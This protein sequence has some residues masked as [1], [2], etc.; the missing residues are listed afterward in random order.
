MRYTNATEHHIV[1][2]TDHREY[3]YV[4]ILP[5]ESDLG[6]HSPSNHNGE[7]DKSYADHMLLNTIP[8]II[9]VIWDDEYS[10]TC[11]VNESLEYLVDVNNYSYLGEKKKWYWEWGY[12]FTEEDYEYA[13]MYGEKIVAE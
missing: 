4:E 5:G 2:I 1:L 12:T 13:K 9:T 11:N 6:G 10:I 8:R 7:V 3:K